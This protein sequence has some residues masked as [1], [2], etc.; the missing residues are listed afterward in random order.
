MASVNQVFQ[1]APMGRTVIIRAV[2]AV[3]ALLLVFAGNLY[4]TLERMKHAPPGVRML[5]ALAPFV[6]IAIFLATLAWERSRPP[7]IR[8]EDNTLVLG[9]KRFPLE[10]LTAAVRDPAVLHRATR[11]WGRSGAGSIRGRFRS[12]RLGKFEAYLTDTEN[13]VV[14]TWP[15]KAV[16]VSP[17]DPEFFIYSARSAAGLR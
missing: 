14:L 10:G 6:P 5:Q 3:G 15:D 7:K 17:A 9:R 12:K 16:A 8:I 2:C 11:T 1:D 4:V 13:A